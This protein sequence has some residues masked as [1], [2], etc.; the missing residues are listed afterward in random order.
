MEHAAF[1]DMYNQYLLESI[2]R[3]MDD[4][5]AIK[6]DDDALQFLQKRLGEKTSGFTEELIRCRFY[7]EML[8]NAPTDILNRYIAPEQF[9]NAYMRE[10]VRI[11]RRRPRGQGRLRRFL[12]TVVRTVHGR[13]AVLAGTTATL[14]E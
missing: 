2:Y 13:N 7:L 14:P 9:A 5:P 3:E 4:N 11:D 6:S 8:P 1:L 12:G 10:P